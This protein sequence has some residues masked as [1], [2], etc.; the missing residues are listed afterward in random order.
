MA[1]AKEKSAQTLVKRLGDEVREL[2][3]QVVDL[4][5]VVNRLEV[6]KHRTEAAARP[7]V[8]RGADP[9]LSPF[10]NW[11]RA[12]GVWCTHMVGHTTYSEF[13][14]SVRATY[15]AALPGV[16]EGSADMVS[17]MT[18]TQLRQLVRSLQ[19]ELQ[20]TQASAAR[21]Q[22]IPRGLSASIE[23]DALSQSRPRSAGKLRAL[24]VSRLQQSPGHKDWREMTKSSSQLG[25]SVTSLK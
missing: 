25:R 17:S 19:S 15:H 9:L 18:D 10:E 24:K 14:D 12:N 1:E 2:K 4:N 5:R 22:G 23:R 3:K 6:E 21:K 7:R 13:E 20:T 16:L 11:K 8:D